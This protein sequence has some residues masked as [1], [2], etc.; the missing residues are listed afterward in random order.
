MAG[1]SI[2]DLR[3]DV[4]KMSDQQVKKKYEFDFSND[5]EQLRKV[6]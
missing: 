5:E 6:I 4:I 2:E 1:E 3:I